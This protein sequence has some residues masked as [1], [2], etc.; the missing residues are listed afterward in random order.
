MSSTEAN[1]TARFAVTA[2]VYVHVLHLP[3][4]CLKKFTDI[5]LS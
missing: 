2:H 4:T 1:V 5:M 3:S